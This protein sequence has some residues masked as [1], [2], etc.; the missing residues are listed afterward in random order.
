MPSTVA[1][2]LGDRLRA[3]SADNQ[4]STS[5]AVL[6]AAHLNLDMLPVALFEHLVMA[7]DSVYF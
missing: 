5:I 7:I 6:V 3:Y 1:S 4:P 2:V